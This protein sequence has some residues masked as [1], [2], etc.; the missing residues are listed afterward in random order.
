VAGNESA[1][2]AAKTASVGDQ[3]TRE[4][5]TPHRD[6][7][8]LFA[9]AIKARWQE[10][11]RGLMGNKLREVKDTV[12]PWETSNRKSRTE[13][14]ILARLRIG[15]TKV[16]HGFLLRG[17]APDE[18]DSCMTPKTVRHLLIECVDHHN[19]RQRVFDPGGGR[20]RVLNLRKVLE[21]DEDMI[22]KLFIFLNVE[23]MLDSI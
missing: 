8:P 17:D 1:D 18:C 15:H 7:Y 16:T 10:V 4:I 2:K 23:Q 5:A 20:R 22:R 11:W 9:S 6:Y 3:E 21:N 12:Q 13:E 19:T 14:V